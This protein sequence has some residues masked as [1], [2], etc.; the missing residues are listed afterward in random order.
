M[1]G[2]AA[3]KKQVLFAATVYSHLANFHLPF[4]GLLRA[5]G[6]EIHAAAFPDGH[7]HRVEETASRCWDISFSRLLFSPANLKAFLQMRRL[8]RAHSFKLI[9]VNSPISAFIVRLAARK[10]E[11][12]P[13]IY[14]VHGFHFYRGAPWLTWVLYFPMEWLAAFWTD[15]MIVLN[16]EDRQT[17]RYLRAISADRVFLLPGVGLPTAGF[18]QPLGTG[19]RESLLSQLGIPADSRCVLCVAELNRNKNQRQLIRAWPEVL[20][21]V[22]GAVLLLAG[23]GAGEEALRR[24]VG[25]LALQERI[26][27]L[28]F[29]GDIPALLQLAEVVALASYREGMPRALMEAAAAGRPVVATDVR[30]SRDVVE[31]GRTGF[32]VPVGDNSATARKIVFLLKNP[33]QAAQMS[34]AA[35]QKSR[36]YELEA[37][38]KEMSVIYHRFLGN[39]ES[40]S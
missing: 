16:E 9:H 20:R 23:E 5:Q 3:L 4:M 15:G 21:A 18:R 1:P 8:I 31:D 35:L 12:G 17:A 6:Y 34:S 32:L 25:Q 10:A 2:T 26:F 30:G 24:E 19:E 22:P 36:N 11:R 14:M 27:F 38:V 13:L 29:R 28:G 40:A 7:K 39:Q 33:E 37:I